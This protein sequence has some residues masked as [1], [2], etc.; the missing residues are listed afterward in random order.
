M[1]ARWLLAIVGFAAACGF[2]S[3]PLPQGA[4]RLAAEP[5]GVQG[6]DDDDVGSGE[7]GSMA[8]EAPDPVDSGAPPEAGEDEPPPVA[9]SGS[10]AMV[11][12]GS[13]AG[14]GPILTELDAAVAPEDAAVPPDEPGPD[15]AEPDAGPAELPEGVLDP[16]DDARACM[17]ELICDAPN[18]EAGICAQACERDA[19]CGGLKDAVFECDHS[20]GVCRLPCDEDERACPK[21]LMCTSRGEDGDEYCAAAPKPEPDRGHGLFERCDLDLGDDDCADGRV[22]HRSSSSQIDGPGY[23]TDECET[24]DDCPMTQAQGGSLSCLNGVCRF[25]CE[26]SECPLGMACEMTG[27][28]PLCQY[29]P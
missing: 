4:G 17:G 26:E 15:A 18:G 5:R 27:A 23:C 20:E 11:D 2:N 12:P 29:A 3:A 10:D 28:L 1:R 25:D 22:C 19:D 16:C 24:T 8:A 14:S 6:A 13:D 9:G 7:A 21:P